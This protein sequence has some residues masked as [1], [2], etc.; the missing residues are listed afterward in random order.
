MTLSRLRLL[1][2]VAVLLLVAVLE[3]SRFVLSPQ[4]TSWSGAI[5]FDAAVVVAVLFFLAAAFWLF[6]DLQGRVARQN[7]ELIA[8][9]EAGLRIATELAP[10]AVLQTV[11]DQARD[12]LRARYGA[13]AVYRSDGSIRLFVTSGIEERYRERIVGGLP[14]GKGLLGITLRR[15]EP[16]RLQKMRSHP[17]SAGFPE[18]HPSMTSLLVAPIICM[19]PYRGNLYL[20]DKR[21]ENG[22]TEDDESTIVRF[23]TQSAIAIDNAYMHQRIKDLAAATER[24]RIA[25]EMHDGLAQVLAY[26]NTKSQ[27]VREYLSRGDVGHASR[28]LDD[29]A[30]AARK[31]YG[32]TR[33][34]ILSLRSLSVEGRPFPEAVREYLESWRERSAIEASVDIAGR[35][36]APPSVETQLLRIIQ[37]ALTNV[38][39][40]SGANRVDVRL[41]QR[42]GELRAVIEDDGA[43]FD[44]A[45]GTD[46]GHPHFGLAIMRERA[47]REG[48]SLAIESE[49]GKGTRVMVSFPLRSRSD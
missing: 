22:F 7:R 15:D 10:E 21:E 31:V 46:D 48:G 29:L 27:A 16:L 17:E 24:Q 37:E 42:N 19:A 14:H 49:R 6:E 5:L 32:D 23:A 38:R 39:K 12:L 36:E 20:T 8:L 33:E 45:A 35:I 40:H 47:E 1:A 11:V 34:A 25:H 9:H 13:L 2:L 43:G 44:P 30:E 18:G 3:Y 41:S 26:V 28:E 4:L